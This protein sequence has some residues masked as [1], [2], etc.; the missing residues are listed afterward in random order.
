MSDDARSLGESQM[1]IPLSPPWGKRKA[2][3][4][5]TSP[6]R[7]GKELAPSRRRGEEREGW[8]VAFPAGLLGETVSICSSGPSLTVRSFHHFLS[9][10]TVCESE[11]APGTQNVQPTFTFNVHNATHSSVSEA[12]LVF[13]QHIVTFNL[14][15]QWPVR[16]EDQY[17]F[18][19]LCH[20]GARG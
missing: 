12:H 14:P 18:L 8:S 4:T 9:H 11:Y 2:R 15:N 6:A 10:S 3:L 19:T 17:L 1:A 20:G 13:R 7:S 5:A 16:F